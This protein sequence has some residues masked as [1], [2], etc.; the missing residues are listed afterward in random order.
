[1]NAIMTCDLCVDISKV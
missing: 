1:M